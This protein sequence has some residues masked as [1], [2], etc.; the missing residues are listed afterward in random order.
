MRHTF[1]IGLFLLPLSLPFVLKHPSAVAKTAEI[2]GDSCAPLKDSMARIRGVL[3]DRDDREPL[4][5]VRI[6]F[7]NLEK[8]LII[9]VITDE[10]GRFDHRISPGH[11]AIETTFTGKSTFRLDSC[12]IESFADYRLNIE[13]GGQESLGSVEKLK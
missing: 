13:L 10:K 6:F 11:Y 9:G 4:M 2:G 12:L 5:D 7:T 3:L 1:L 8:R